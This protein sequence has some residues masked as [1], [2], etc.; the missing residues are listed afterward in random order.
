MITLVKR[1]LE[2]VSVYKK[3]SKIPDQ[4][5]VENID[6]NFI[7]ICSWKEHCELVRHSS[8]IVSDLKQREKGRIEKFKGRQMEKLKI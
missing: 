7:Y 4:R 5:G 2:M 8:F 3:Y 6:C 1:I